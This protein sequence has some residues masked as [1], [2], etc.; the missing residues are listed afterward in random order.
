VAIIKRRE[1]ERAAA[2]RE[3]SQLEVERSET[4]F[5]VGDYISQ[6]VGQNRE[7]WKLVATKSR[8]L[9]EESNR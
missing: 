2:N 7:A 5:T 6:I 1:D 8:I 4:F 3:L 9:A